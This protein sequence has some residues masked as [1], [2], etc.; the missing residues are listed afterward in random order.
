MKDIFN[1]V[2]IKI[3][4]KKLYLTVNEKPP[5]DTDGWLELQYCEGF[6]ILQVQ[7]YLILG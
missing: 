1:R 3:S 7:N 5:A 2:W 6:G 4:E